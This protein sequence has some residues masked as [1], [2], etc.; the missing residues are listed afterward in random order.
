MDK[1]KKY[2]IAAFIII[3]VIVIIISILGMILLG[4]KPVILQGQVEATEIRISRK[5]SGTY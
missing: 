1:T 2:L 4:N 3:L 5:T